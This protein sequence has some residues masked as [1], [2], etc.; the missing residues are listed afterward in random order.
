MLK[1]LCV[2]LSRPNRTI[3][4][5]KATHL[6]MI[7]SRMIGRQW[8]ICVSKSPKNDKS[9]RWKGMFKKRK[10]GS[11]CLH[12]QNLI[13]KTN[14]KKG[15]HTF[16]T[17]Q[18][19]HSSPILSRSWRVKMVTC[20][21]KKFCDEKEKM[22]KFSPGQIQ[23]LTRSYRR[24]LEQNSNKSCLQ[25][26]WLRGCMVLWSRLWKLW[27][28][29]SNTSN[30]VWSLNSLQAPCQLGFCKCYVTLGIYVYIYLHKQNTCLHST[31][32]LI[33]FK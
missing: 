13:K 29:F 25:F 23:G 15:C 31:I 20:W 28:S 19:S 10:K 4:L 24:G 1:V 22:L 9:F 16:W 26:C 27:V 6:V 3:F 2:Y 7:K 21:F 17:G 12:W 5:Y 32:F 30:A 14:F 33:W 18:S 11:H 8:W